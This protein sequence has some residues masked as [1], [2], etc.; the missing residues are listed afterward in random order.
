MVL[1][2]ASIFFKLEHNS[3]RNINI[4]YLANHIMQLKYEF[5]LKHL[6]VL[7]FFAPVVQKYLKTWM[8]LVPYSIHI[9]TEFW[10]I[11]TH[12]IHFPIG[13]LKKH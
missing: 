13:L 1:G 10:K 5:V 12:F 3:S 4:K 6:L 11:K 9:I 2:Q 7:M 8:L